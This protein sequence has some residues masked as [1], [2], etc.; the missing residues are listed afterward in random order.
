MPY[1]PYTTLAVTGPSPEGI[2]QVE[3]ARPKKLNAMNSA[4]WTECAALFTEVGKDYDTRVVVLSAQGRAFTAGLDLTDFAAPK[5]P[6]VGRRA[7]G[8]RGHIMHCQAAFTAIENCHQPV[9]SVAH[10][11]VVGGGIDLLSS[12]CIR[13]FSQDAF[14]T[15]KEV[16]AGLAADVGTLQRMPKIIG[17]DG[18]VR[19]LA[20]TSRRFSADEALKLGFATKVFPTKE[21]AMDGAMQ[22]AAS[23]ASKSP[24]AIAGTKR[25]LVHSRDLSVRDG[26]EYVAAWNMSMLQAPDMMKAAQASLRKKQATFAKL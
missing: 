6:D 2:L 17:N 3:L 25:V 23:I 5:A 20:Y 16:D 21:A 10:G 15:I 24:I 9:I 11:A 13:Y 4:F 18:L 12:V 8:L 22:L 19:E 1:G 14:L 26:L 7:W